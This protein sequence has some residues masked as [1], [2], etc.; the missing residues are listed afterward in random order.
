VAV[1]PDAY[2]RWSIARD[3][4]HGTGR[5][6]VDRSRVGGHADPDTLLDAYVLELIEAAPPLT[7]EQR[8]T[9][10]LLLRQPGQMP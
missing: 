5:D 2:Q 7:G 3:L 6:T 10:A 4:L 9:L 8:H 1:L